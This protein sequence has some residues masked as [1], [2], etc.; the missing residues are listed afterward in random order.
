MRTL[1]IS[2]FITI[3]FFVSFIPVAQAEIPFDFTQCPTGPATVLSSRGELF[4]ENP[5]KDFPRAGS[6][7]IRAVRVPA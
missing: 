3:I 6:R 5:G 1:S 7:V 4:A 2:A